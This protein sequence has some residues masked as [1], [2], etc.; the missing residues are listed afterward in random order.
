MEAGGFVAGLDLVWVGRRNGFARYFLNWKVRRL[1]GR[2]IHAGSILAWE[3]GVA[4]WRAFV[5]RGKGAE[6]W[7]ELGG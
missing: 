1:D 5:F 3:N 7:G 6:C 2:E 4:G